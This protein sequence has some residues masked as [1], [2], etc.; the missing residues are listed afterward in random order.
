M[1]FVCYLLLVLAAITLMFLFE[2]NTDS[3]FA[4]SA[5]LGTGVLGLLVYLLPEGVREHMPSSRF[6]RR[7]LGF[8]ALVPCVGLAYLVVAHLLYPLRN[9]L[10]DAFDQRWGR[11]P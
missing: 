10:M 8:F 3:R 1:E 4:V 7:A 5:L 2:E 6:A 9:K 11:K